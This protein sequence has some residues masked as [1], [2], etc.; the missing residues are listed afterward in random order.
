MKKE[1]LIL[2]TLIMTLTPCQVY[3]DIIKDETN[4]EIVEPTEEIDW[5]TEIPE[6]INHRILDKMFDE[7]DYIAKNMYVTSPLNMREKPNIESEVEKILTIN[8]EVKVV[9]EYE[10]WSRIVIENED[11]DEEEYY[12]WNKYL[13]DEKVEI[14]KSYLGN[15]KLTAYC[16]CSKCCGKWAGGNTAS[17]VAPAQGRT[18]AMGGIPFG[19][20]LLING[21]IYTVEDR[22]TPYGHVDIFFNSHS[23]ALQFGLQYAD[24]YRLG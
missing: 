3:A 18:V 17:G 7:N 22:G 21:R 1:L 6:D 5:E 16:N 13:S 8:T 24:V 12:V 15:F 20:R 4:V 14:T 19:T 10:S 23:E 2:L 9:A 11:G